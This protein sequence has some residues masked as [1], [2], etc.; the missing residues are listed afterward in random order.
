MNINYN[1]KRN[2][3]YVL[4]LIFSNYLVFKTCKIITNIL[5]PEWEK[6]A[7]ELGLLILF[8]H[9]VL[10]TVLTIM[11]IV[12]SYFVLI[13]I[14]WLLS[15]VFNHFFF[16]KIEINYYNGEQILTELYNINRLITIITIIVLILGIKV[17]FNILSSFLYLIFPLISYLSIKRKIKNIIIPKTNSKLKTKTI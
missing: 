10:L 4:L 13:L 11:V 5:A 2:L 1:I 3:T 15:I 12:T 9:Y 17:P 8:M 14:L 7:Q 6:G 16:K